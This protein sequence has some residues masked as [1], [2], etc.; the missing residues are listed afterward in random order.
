MNDAPSG[1]GEK[2]QGSPQQRIV[3]FGDGS[4][5]EYSSE[6]LLRRCS[7]GYVVLKIGRAD[8]KDGARPAL[9]AAEGAVLERESYDPTI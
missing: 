2:A 8:P 5:G 1:Y 7:W 4:G 3:G 6:P 9:P